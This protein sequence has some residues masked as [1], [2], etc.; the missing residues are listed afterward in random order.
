[1]STIG[2]IDAEHRTGKMLMI[3]RAAVDERKPM[4]AVAA[5]G[6]VVAGLVMAGNRTEARLYR[7]R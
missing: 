6:G 2:I 7:V 5:G 3:D 4:T 1:M